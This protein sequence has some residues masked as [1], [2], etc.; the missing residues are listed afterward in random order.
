MALGYAQSC[1]IGALI[2]SLF[3][4]LYFMTF[5][6]TVQILRKKLVPGPVF[7]YLATTTIVLFVLITMRMVLDNKA[8]VEAFTNDPLTP[9]AAEIYFTSFGNGA[10]FRTGTYI[11]LTVVADVFIVY[12]V[13]AVWSRAILATIVPFLLAVA[14]IVSG[15]LFVQSIRELAAGDSPDGKSTATHALIFYS[16]TLALNVVCTFLIALRLYIAQRQST[17]AKMAPSTNLNKLMVIVI[18]SAALYSACLV[19]MLV[20]T[21]LGNNAQ[22]CILSMMPGIVGLA[23]S[24]IIVRAGAGVSPHHTTADTTGGRM[25][26]AEGRSQFATS[27]FDDHETTTTGYPRSEG[28]STRH[29]GFPIQFKPGTRST[30]EHTHAT[31]TSDEGPREREKADKGKVEA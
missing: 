12:R 28:T 31:R 16:F 19:A 17:A 2:E 25:Q 9:N 5:L 23:F 15:A 26:F 7:A 8:A 11:A 20:P 13:W 21:A 4:G 29:R 3:Y 6:Q 27:G 10:M 18:E 22:Y 30:G 24:L 14:D 1:L